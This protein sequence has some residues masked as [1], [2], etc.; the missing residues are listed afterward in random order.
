MTD[1]TRTE[2]VQKVGGSPLLRLGFGRVVGRYALRPDRSLPC[3]Q[4]AAAT[5]DPVSLRQTNL[6]RVREGSLVDGICAGGLL[7]DSREI[8][9]ADRSDTAGSLPHP[10]LVLGR[11]VKMA[12]EIL[13]RLD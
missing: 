12:T 11:P 13:V 2:S 3:L 7:D 4:F 5:A 9:A 10:R 6:R 8:G 1:T